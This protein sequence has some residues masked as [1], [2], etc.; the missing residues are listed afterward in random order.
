M[1]REEPE[2]TPA[3]GRFDPLL[4]VALAVALLLRAAALALYWDIEGR[5]DERVHYVLGVLVTHLGPD[6]ITRWAPAY[7]FFQAFAYSLLRPEPWAAKALQVLVSTATVGLIYALTLRLGGRRPARIAAFVAALYPSFIAYSHYL[8]P[9]TLYILLLTGSVYAFF[10]KPGNPARGDLAAS[11]VL[12]GLAV[13]TRSV[14]VHFLPV[15]I[16]WSLLRGRWREAR[17]VAIVA[18]IALA[19]VA[20]WTLRN[21]RLYERFVLVDPIAGLVGYYAFNKQPL[22]RDIGYRQRFDSDRPRCRVPVLLGRDPLP[23]VE[24]LVALFPPAGYRFLASTER[25]EHTVYTMRF[26][27]SVNLPVMG[28][29][30]VRNGLAYLRQHPWQV[31]GMLPVRAYAFFGPTSFLLRSSYTGV[32]PGG[33]LGEAAYPGVK[34]AVAASTMAVF[35]LAI[36]AFGR[37][38]LPPIAEWLALFSAYYV[39]LH[40]VAT[41]FSRYRLPLVPFAIALGALWLAKPRAP[42]GRPRR[43]IVVGLLLGYTALCIHYLAFR[44]P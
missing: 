14:A 44:L 18:G 25:L 15:W 6:A 3:K 10:R 26:E 32:Y 9:E 41:T 34:A 43:A 27:A 22:N 23:P 38:G 16:G 1:H 5:G 31:L 20:P 21:A 35:L 37:P 11:G 40:A 42:A 17:N 2:R 13:L 8:Y 7:E 33:P 28:S 30:E 12:F 19:V 39:A 24:E 4:L 29:C 36:L